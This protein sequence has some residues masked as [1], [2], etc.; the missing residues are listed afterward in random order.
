M[1]RSLFPLT[2][3]PATIETIRNKHNLN[4]AL[5]NLILCKQIVVTFKKMYIVS[6]FELNIDYGKNL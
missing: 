5:Y 2:L 1:E 4:I 6:Y 3:Q